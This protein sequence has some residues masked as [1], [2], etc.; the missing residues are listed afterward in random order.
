MLSCKWLKFFKTIYIITY[1][2]FE[3]VNVKRNAKLWLRIVTWVS[4][5]SSIASSSSSD[6]WPAMIE[7]DPDTEYYFQLENPES[8]FPVSLWIVLILEKINDSIYYC[9]ESSGT[10]RFMKNSILFYSTML[11]CIEC[12]TPSSCRK[13]FCVT[14]MLDSSSKTAWILTRKIIYMQYGNICSEHIRTGRSI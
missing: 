1:E 12:F 10:W 7:M 14:P 2:K 13:K 9:F 5:D 6:R 4:S 11:I 8:M 3:L